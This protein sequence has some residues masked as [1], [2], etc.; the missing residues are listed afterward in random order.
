MPSTEAYYLS[1]PKPFAVSL[2]KMN[3]SLKHSK[4]QVFI[5]NG[6]ILLSP[7]SYPPPPHFTLGT[8]AI[9]DPD[10]TTTHITQV[11]DNQF[12]TLA[13]VPSAPRFNLKLLTVLKR[14][15]VIHKVSQRYRLDEQLI[16]EWTKLKNNLTF[17]SSTI[18][19]HTDCLFP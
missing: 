16:K 18:S 4:H 14:D 7:Y 8:L 19:C 3:H 17:I 1:Q 15:F 12:P 9:N 13:W 5:I 2:V 11:S 6:S 10:P